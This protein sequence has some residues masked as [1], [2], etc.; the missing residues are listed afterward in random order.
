MDLS[1]GAVLSLTAPDEPIEA[2]SQNPG[3]TRVRG[4]ESKRPNDNPPDD[5]AFGIELQ[6]RQEAEPA[7]AVADG[8]QGIVEAPVVAGEA[9]APVPTA[10]IQEIPLAMLLDPEANRNA[11][12]GEID[13]LL[14]LAAELIDLPFALAAEL[15]TGT[16]P[17]TAAESAPVE[18]G[19][20]LITTPLL[21]KAPKADPGQAAAQPIDAASG[22]P[23][24]LAASVADDLIPLDDS[25][26]PVL[27][28]QNPATQTNE[29]LLNQAASAQ[30]ASAHSTQLRQE[31]LAQVQDEEIASRLQTV[32]PGQTLQA[33]EQ[34]TAERPVAPV[35]QVGQGS[36]SAASTLQAATQQA[37]P[38]DR[39]IA[40][41]VT[42]AV[43]AELPNGDRQL[44][45]RLTP[46]ELGTVRV[47][48][49]EHQGQLHVRMS[50]EDDSVRHALERALPQLRQDLR[51]NDAPVADLQLADS[52][53]FDLN[54]REE[55]QAQQGRGRRH[56]PTAFS[57]DGETGLEEP[58]AT[59]GRHSVISA[60]AIDATA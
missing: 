24:A 56:G 25:E 11:L 35:L 4:A 18:G 1:T 60:D 39:A 43:L 41:Q 28:S 37:G 57:L 31:H 59:T 55:Q 53:F 45:L 12:T 19:E 20:V 7:E 22:N 46:P 42:R 3:T 17:T 10:Q 13:P 23:L 6:R 14:A 32:T 58:A 30:N 15:P 33:G 50:A 5:T 8:E 48:I 2:R 40:N 34:A 16:L 52:A 9:A 21:P 51:S 36:S 29:A 47:Q 54:G 44:I 26:E 27:G 49:I 38:A